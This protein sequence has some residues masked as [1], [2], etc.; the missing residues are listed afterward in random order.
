MEYKI[1]SG[2]SHI[3]LEVQVN[4]LLKNGWEPHGSMGY[5]I[6]PSD[7]YVEFYQ[8]MIRKPPKVIKNHAQG[9]FSTT[10]KTF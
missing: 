4:D 9:R 3:D 5:T 8:P 10:S 6:F 1:V 2:G 7:N